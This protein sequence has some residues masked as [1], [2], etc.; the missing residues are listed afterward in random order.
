MFE[1]KNYPD[2]RYGRIEKRTV[3][4]IIAETPADLGTF[5]A[6]PSEMPAGRATLR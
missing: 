1:A 4:A 2:T 3:V 6:F 5:W